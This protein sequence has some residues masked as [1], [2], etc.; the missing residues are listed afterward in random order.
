MKL[1]DLS[2]S[3]SASLRFRLDRRLPP[4]E[5]DPSQFR[6]VVM[7][8]V[9]NASEALGDDPGSIVI[10]TGTRDCS[11]EDLQGALLGDEL[12]PGAYVFLRVADTGCGMNEEARDKVFDPFFSTKF[13][14]R[15]L[16]MAA[17]LGIVRGHGGAIHLETAPGRGTIVTVL[18]PV[19]DKPR[20]VVG[21][22]EARE[23][24]RGEGTILVVDD[25]PIVQS[26]ARET[27]EEGGF[28]V[29]TAADG[30]EA[31]EIYGQRGAEIALVLLDMTMPRLGGT[32][33]F[34]ELREMD[35]GVRVILTSGYNEDEAVDRIEGDD[36]AG[37]VQK[38]WDP[39]DLLEKVLVALR[40]P[41]P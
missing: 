23:W 11:A 25:E 12:A 22:A 26:V 37:F 3:K 21:T 39:A 16:G 20:P 32:A 17:V 18:L 30:A 34:Q 13:T 15:G 41:D 5:A 40:P 7:N 1:L 8:L 4:I 27:L 19:S 29:L 24:Q 33:C 28:E 38:P 6:Q 31:L 35:P 36:L 14:G 2:I 9:T 10:A